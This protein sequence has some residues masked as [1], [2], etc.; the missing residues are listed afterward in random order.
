MKLYLH[1]N[2][3]Q[4]GPYTPEQIQQ[5][6]AAGQITGETLAWHEGNTEWLPVLSV[7]QHLSANASEPAV[8]RAIPPFTGH[9]A[10]VSPIR[11]Q[12]APVT[13]HPSSLPVAKPSRKFGCWFAILVA[14][15]I[16][17]G[18]TFFLIW[19]S[20][21]PQGGVLLKNEMEPYASRYLD[22][23]K[24][25]TPSEDLIAYYDETITLKAT[26][27][28]I[29]TSQRIIYL[30][31]G[32]TDSIDLK[33]IQDVKCRSTTLTNTIEIYS[34]TGKIM[35]IDIA[36]ANGFQ[37]FVN[38]LNSERQRVSNNPSSRKTGP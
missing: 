8:P 9:S 14:L 27:A 18:G 35:K 13:F 6:L 21:A 37:T 2:E 23:H 36:H 31:N 33:D 10:K 24:I 1:V 5:L 17:G 19:L 32:Q 7:M 29:L 25:L 16:A 3:Q 34:T 12:Q 11:T 4:V 26:E 20:S 28:A 30:K 15:V 38:A 22:E